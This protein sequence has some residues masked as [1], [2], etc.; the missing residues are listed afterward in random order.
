MTGDPDVTPVGFAATDAPAASVRRRRNPLWL[1]LAVLL[2]GLG[3]AG[4][5]WFVVAQIGN[6]PGRDDA[7]AAGR[8]A[9][10]GGADTAVARFSGQGDYTV[11][12]D[13]DGVTLS[14][15]RE[16]IV[17]ATNCVATFEGGGS[18]R[19]R[20]ARQGASVTIGD[21]STVGAFT[22]A[23]G[24]V[25]VGCRQLPFGRLGRRRALTAERSF[26]VT[27]GSPDVGWKPWVGLFGGI[28]LVILA[29]PTWGRHRAGYLRPR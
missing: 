21:R 2:A 28:G 15:N 8:V 29:V 27:P 20:G 4:I 11:W 13:L 9:A 1:V 16:L 3:C 6:V 25:V 5:V 19:F 22:A 18:A 17:A 26:F 23:A 10:L 12:L 7:V 14:N 24:E